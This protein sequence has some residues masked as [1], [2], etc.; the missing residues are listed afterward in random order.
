MMKNMVKCD[1]YKLLL[2]EIN[3]FV[4]QIYRYNIIFHKGY[5]IL[6]LNL[7]ASFYQNINICFLNQIAMY[8]FT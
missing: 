6:A 4:Q 1:S 2:S 3:I 8:Y 5:K 7:Y